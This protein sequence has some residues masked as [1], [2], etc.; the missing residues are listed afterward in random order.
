M[1]VGV[2]SNPKRC[3][4]AGTTDCGVDDIFALDRAAKGLSATIQNA[5]DAY[6][7]F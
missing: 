1:G 2:L 4:V 7:G 3:D 5:C 6:F